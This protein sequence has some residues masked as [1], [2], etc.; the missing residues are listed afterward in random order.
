VLLT[1]LIERTSQK[2][3]EEMLK[4][5]E[6]E[7]ERLTAVKEAQAMRFQAISRM[8]PLI[9]PTIYNLSIAR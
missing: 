3:G 5:R 8:G 2:D 9:A 6:R 1:Y 4:A 7:R